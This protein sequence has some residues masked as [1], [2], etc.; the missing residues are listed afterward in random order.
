MMSLHCSSELLNAPSMRSALSLVPGTDVSE[1]RTLPQHAVELLFLGTG[2]SVPSKYRNGMPSRSWIKSYWI[3]AVS[4][5]YLRLP[6][7]AILLDAGEGTLGQLR[8]F[9]GSTS[10]QVF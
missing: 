1:E 9:R 4:A 10:E 5:I 6:H 8:R 7:G 2:S 3:D